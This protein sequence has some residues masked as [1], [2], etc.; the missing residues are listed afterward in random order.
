MVDIKSKTCIY[1]NCNIR[2][3]YNYINEKKA[4]HCNTHKLENMVDIKNKTCIYENC[5]I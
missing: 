1:E 5:K 4:S 2:P 3:I